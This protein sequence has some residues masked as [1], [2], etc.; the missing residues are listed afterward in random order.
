[1]ALVP[2]VRP[3]VR[4]GVTSPAPSARRGAPAVPPLLV[5]LAA[6]AVAGT[7]VL[8]LLVGGGAPDDGGSALPTA[9]PV[10]GW[11]LPAVELLARLLAV[12]TVGR[13]VLAGLLV[14]AD[15][16]GA[17]EVRR[18][19]HA[20]TRWA[21]LWLSAEVATLLLTASSLY[22]VPVTGLSGSAVAG[23]LTTLPVGRA[24]AVVGLVLVV[25]ALGCATATRAWHARLLLPLALGAVVVPVVM[26]GH[27]AGADDHVA[28]VTTLSVHV[29]S[30]SVWVGGLAAL[31][32]AGRGHA[33]TVTAVRRFSVLAL[34]CVGLLAATGVLAAVLVGGVP[35]WGV[36]T[37]GWGRLLAAKTVLLLVLAGLGLAHRR[38]CLP[39]LVSGRPRAFLR[40]GAVEVVLM[41]VTV[42]VSVA[43][44]SSPPPA[45]APPP[46]PLQGAPS[47]QAPADGTAPVTD[48]GD[49][50]APA[51]VDPAV[52]DMSGHDHGELS[53]TVLVDQERFHVSGPVRPGQRVT[54][55]NSSRTAVS[56]TAADGSFDADVP[57]RTFITF[58]APGSPGPY[59]F[60]SGH[61]PGFADT[62]TVSDS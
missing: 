6:A 12:L 23:L 28:A 49:V 16:A 1:V 34:G 24:A 59:G 62:L 27:S 56:L 21:A 19:V 37:G 30:A 44:G 47:A 57:A 10:T 54:V 18:L 52:E 25:L 13:L 48:P 4:P 61:D 46:A 36:L 3:D 15:H 5:G 39:A 42:A 43:L 29:V 7:L 60:T 45:P 55:Y 22:A 20:T 38:R 51:A 35:T 58:E 32:G 41:A 14:P 17:P 11:G 50:A 33:W 40:L 31:L 53:V 8:A 2:D 26:A 9:G